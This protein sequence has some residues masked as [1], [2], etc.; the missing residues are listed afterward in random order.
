LIFC[1]LRCCLADYARRI[2]AIPSAANSIRIANVVELQR[3]RPACTSSGKCIALAS[4][5]RCERRR[6][7]PSSPRPKTAS[8]RI[9]GALENHFAISLTS[10]IHQSGVSFPK[11]RIRAKWTC[12]VVE[13]GALRRRIVNSV[14]CFTL[15][16]YGCLKTNVY[17]APASFVITVAEREREL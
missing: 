12:A 4:S 8:K 13:I 11:G 2:A 15:A 5:S 6:V 14:N 3:N 10:L 16:T 7:S 17:A 9:A 1:G